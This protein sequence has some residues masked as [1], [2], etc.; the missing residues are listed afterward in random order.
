LY[1]AKIPALSAANQTNWLS[2]EHGDLYLAQTALEARLFVKAD[3]S[4]VQTWKAMAD[5]KIASLMRFRREAMVPKKLKTDI[6]IRTPYD[7]ASD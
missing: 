6:A 5:E 2:S 4:Q 1:Y 7:I 3:P